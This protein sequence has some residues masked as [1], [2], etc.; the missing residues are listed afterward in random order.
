VISPLQAARSR[1]EYAAAAEELALA[2]VDHTDLSLEIA[3]IEELGNGGLDEAG[4]KQLVVL[5]LLCFQQ[6][7]DSIDLDV[8]DTFGKLYVLTLQQDRLK[9]KLLAKQRATNAVHLKEKELAAA[10]ELCASLKQE[11]QVC[12]ASTRQTW[13]KVEEVRSHRTLQ[14]T[15][16]M[17]VRGALRSMLR[18]DSDAMRAAGVLEG[19][20]ASCSRSGCYGQAATGARAGFGQQGRG[21]RGHQPA[22][23]RK[24]RQRERGPQ[25]KAARQRPHCCRR[26]A[27]GQAHQSAHRQR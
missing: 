18:L 1:S 26:R 8:S 4:E 22:I 21:E 6:R 5:K 3:K 9:E 15:P 16:G 27:A 13:E 7:R 25:A 11:I 2:I 14:D 23:I 12:K 24:I 20:D 17:Q 19:T 10:E